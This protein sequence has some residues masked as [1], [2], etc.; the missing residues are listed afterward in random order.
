VLERNVEEGCASF[1]KHVSSV[2]ER[3][4][5]MNTP[6]AA[7]RDPGRDRE[8]AVDENRAPV[9]DEDPRGHGRKAVPSGEEAARLVERGTDEPAV[10]DAGARLVTLAEGKRRLVAFDPLFG[11]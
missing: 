8:V 11:R 1:G 4:V 6:A 10:D 9:A 3:G 7:I 5:H 2:A